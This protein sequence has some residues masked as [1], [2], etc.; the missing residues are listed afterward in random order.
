M[1]PVSAA[2]FTLLEILVALAILAILMIGLIKI[3]SDNTRNLWHIENK[4]LATLIA[5]NHATELRLAETKPE[6]TDGWETQA[7]R[8][9]YWQARRPITPSAGLWRYRISVYLK[10]DAE[11]YAVLTSWIAPAPDGKTVDRPA[12][13]AADATTPAV[14]PD[15]DADAPETLSE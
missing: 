13:P 7:G 14:E 2:G 10:G 11:P 4:T 15:H 8:R 5:Q 6:Q 1:K 9:W 12:E 3:V